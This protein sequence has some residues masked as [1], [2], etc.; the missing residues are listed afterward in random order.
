MSSRIALLVGLPLLLAATGCPA[1]GVAP[2]P[3]PQPEVK[4]SEPP[5]PKEEPTPPPPRFKPLAELFPVGQVG[6]PTPLA[7]V[8]FADDEAAVRGKLPDLS[9]GATLQPSDYEGVTIRLQHFKQSQ[10]LRLVQIQ[11]PEGQALP[12]LRER[13]GAPREVVDGGATLRCWTDRAAGLQAILGDGDRV[14]VQPLMTREAVLGDDPVKL[15]FEVEPL[16]GMPLERVKEVYASAVAD[17]AVVTEERV[18]LNLAPPACAT[19]PTFVDL[20]VEGGKVTRAHVK[21]DYPDDASRDALLEQIK[22]KLGE[23]LA[24]K[25]TVS[26]YRRADPK[27][28][29]SHDPAQRRVD[30]FL[31]AK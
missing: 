13:W 1:G 4:R 7:A 17:S 6:M 8:S 10:L 14:L 29:V 25:E 5:P 19:L 12:T 9:E 18:V 21:L 22:R 27:I 2:Q 11:V 15:G 24:T 23:P 30:V 28:V 31:T 16:V 26:T 3:Q 20:R